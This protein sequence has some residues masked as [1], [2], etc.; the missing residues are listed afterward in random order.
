MSVVELTSVERLQAAESIAALKAR[1]F[2]FMDTKRWD[3]WQE[4][5][6]PDAVMDVRGEAKAMRALGFT[7]PDTLTLLWHGSDAIRSAVANALRNLTSVHHGHMPEL[8]ILSAVAARGI[9]AMEDL[10]L[11]GKDAPVAGFRGYGHY[12]ETYTKL[13][14]RW[15]IQTVLLER[16]DIR[17]IAHP[18]D[19]LAS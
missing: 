5:F 17:P 1:Y 3:E 19:G 8:E 10:I 14:G 15:R 9:W 12:H 2:R 11:Y 18:R 6:A 7:V 16:L 4:L 13:Q